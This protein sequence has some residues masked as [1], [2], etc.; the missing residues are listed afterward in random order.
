M[1]SHKRVAFLCVTEL[2]PSSC[3]AAGHDLLGEMSLAELKERLAL[4]KQSER[5]ER[6][7]RRGHILEEKQRKKQEM[8]EKL[9]TIE[10]HRTVL[11][12]AAA[13]R[14]GTGSQAPSKSSD[15]VFASF[16]KNPHLF[17]K[18]HRKQMLRLRNCT[19]VVGEKMKF[20]C[21]NSIFNVV[22]KD[23]KCKWNK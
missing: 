4:L 19:L 5:A 8:L 16:V 1:T 22:Y 10:M 21:Y 18:E 17:T 6:E 12:K 11:A 3:Q 14:S 2:I 9:D 15:I 13:N 23:K 20:K 7:E